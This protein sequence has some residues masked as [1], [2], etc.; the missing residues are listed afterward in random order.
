MGNF[1]ENDSADITVGSVAPDF[2]LVTESNARW[3]LSDHR[4]RVVVLLFYPQ[5]ETFV[6][7]RQLCSVRDH[8]SEYL[9]T[10]AVVVGISPGTPEQHSQ[11]SNRLK[12]PIPLL[13]DPKR[14]ITQVFAK[15]WL[16]PVSLT[17]GITVIDADGRIRNRNVMLRA[18]RPSDE[19]IIA[20]VYAARNDSLGDRFETLKSRFDRLRGRTNE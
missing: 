3:R 5:N 18:F 20:D 13:A 15:H 19:R 10:K 14:E 11:F 1:V 16:F 17:R 9:E 8:W 4:G 2:E 6:C 12:L 7:N